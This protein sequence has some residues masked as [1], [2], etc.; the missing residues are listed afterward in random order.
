MNRS[1]PQYQHPVWVL[2]RVAADQHYVWMLVIQ[3]GRW[4]MS[5]LLYFESSSLLM[6]WEK[7]QKMA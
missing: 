3:Y 7:Q 6:N 5:Q 1:C 4:L 2:V